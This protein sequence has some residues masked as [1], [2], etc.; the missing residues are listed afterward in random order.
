MLYNT[1]MEI[2]SRFDWRS[3]CPSPPAL[4]DLRI[5]K[6]RGERGRSGAIFRLEGRIPRL[7]K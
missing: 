4:L 2:V 5:G 6:G 7:W 1:Y 3:D